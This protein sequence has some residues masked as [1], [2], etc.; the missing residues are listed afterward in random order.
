[1]TSLLLWMH[2]N[3]PMEQIKTTSV[4]SLRVDA[5]SMEKQTDASWCEML[6]EEANM[7][8]T[9]S[10]LLQISIKDYSTLNDDEWA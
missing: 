3:L 4:S 9:C 8:F 2:A 7:T 10:K 6:Q 5:L 1:M